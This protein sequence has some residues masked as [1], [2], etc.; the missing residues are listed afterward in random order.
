MYLVQ[1]VLTFVAGVSHCGHCDNAVSNV[2]ILVQCLCLLW[3]SRFLIFFAVC[4]N[5]N[6]HE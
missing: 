3:F 2:L 1:I 5:T 4:I 6:A